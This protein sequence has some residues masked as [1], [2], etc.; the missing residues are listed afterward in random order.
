MYQA[1]VD[2][3]FTLT[4]EEALGLILGYVYWFFIAFYTPYD[5]RRA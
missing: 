4:D 3:I 2:W 1:E 5:D